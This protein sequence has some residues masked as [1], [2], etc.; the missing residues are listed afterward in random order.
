MGWYGYVGW[1]GSTWYAKE[2]KI[3]SMQSSIPLD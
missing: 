2:K 1:I 3:K